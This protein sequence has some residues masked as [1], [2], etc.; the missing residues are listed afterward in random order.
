MIFTILILTGLLVGFVSSFFGIGGGIITIPALYNIFP[1][2]APQT[3]IGSSLTMIFFNSVINTITFVRGGRIP[4]FKLISIIALAMLVGSVAGGH[5]INLLSGTSIKIIF[6]LLVAFSLFKKII[7]GKRHADNLN[8]SF[9]DDLNAIALIK[10]IPPAFIAGLISGIT[11][12]GGGIIIIPFFISFL[13]MPYRWIPVYS[14]VAMA[15]SCFAAV[16]TYSFFSPPVENNFP[17]KILDNFQMG[18]VNLLI[19]LALSIG[20]AIAS[21]FGASLSNRISKKSAEYLFLGLLV[22]ILVKTII[23]IV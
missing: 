20:A 14:N 5:L 3:I 16:I 21:Q 2:T 18:Q 19:V 17:L 22:F 7:R 9:A 10:M 6:A 8:E 23:D 15:V 12:L 13:K 11:G 4:N 1:S